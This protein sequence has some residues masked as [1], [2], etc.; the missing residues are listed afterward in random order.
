MHIQKLFVIIAFNEHHVELLLKT[1]RYI[2]YVGKI[3]QAPFKEFLAKQKA[4]LHRKVGTHVAQESSLLAWLFEKLVM[5]MIAYFVLSI[6]NSMAQN[7]HRRL[8]KRHAK[9]GGPAPHKVAVS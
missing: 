4:K 9:A 5:A 2:P 7:Y 8:S 1:L 3:L 6:I